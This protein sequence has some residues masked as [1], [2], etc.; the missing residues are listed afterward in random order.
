MTIISWFQT[1]DVPITSSQVASSIGKIVWSRQIWGSIFEEAAASDKAETFACS[2]CDHMI[3]SMQGHFRFLWDALFCFTWTMFNCCYKELGWLSISAFIS[4]DDFFLPRFSKADESLGCLS[5]A[6]SRKKS[7]KCA[8]WHALLDIRDII[9]LDCGNSALL[10]FTISYYI[11]LSLAVF[12]VDARCRGSHS[13]SVFAAFLLN[14]VNFLCIVTVFTQWH[15]SGQTCTWCFDLAICLWPGAPT[16]SLIIR[17]VGG[18]KKQSVWRFH[19]QAFWV[20]IISVISYNSAFPC[21]VIPCWW[22]IKV[23]IFIIWYF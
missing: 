19:I 13:L 6:A 10:R 8:Q 4:L 2:L 1:S 9:E 12:F 7:W 22:I 5:H 16:G 15:R 23:I 21:Q 14:K 18:F 11:Y 17:K 3:V 20:S